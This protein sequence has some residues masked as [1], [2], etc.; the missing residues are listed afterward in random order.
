MVARTWAKEMRIR[1]LGELYREGLLSML[2]SFTMSH[3]QGV[4]Y[5][6]RGGGA[7]FGEHE[8]RD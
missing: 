4:G 3:D 5:G 8:I 6:R 7:A 1:K 2:D